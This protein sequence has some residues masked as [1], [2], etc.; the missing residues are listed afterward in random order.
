MMHQLSQNVLKNRIRSCKYLN[1][2]LISENVLQSLEQRSD[3]NT[4]TARSSILEFTDGA[5]SVYDEK[6]EFD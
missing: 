5:C 1:T 2:S 6:F 4:S 3:V